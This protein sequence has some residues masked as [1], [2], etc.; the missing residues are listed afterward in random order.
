MDEIVGKLQPEF[1]HRG[2]PS[3]RGPGDEFSARS[4]ANDV[5]I[6][7]VPF[8]REQAV[9]NAQRYL[10]GADALPDLW[11]HYSAKVDVYVDDCSF[12]G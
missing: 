7:Y 9:S 2:W 8:Y 4:P 10:G 1:S 12:K 3:Q 11:S 6:L 5:C